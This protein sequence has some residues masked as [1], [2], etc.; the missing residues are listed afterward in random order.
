MCHWLT[1]QFKI[2][3]LK[4]DRGFA[5]VCERGNRVEKRSSGRFNAMVTN[6]NT[7]TSA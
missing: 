1:L 6:R 7:L 5:N 2:A 4:T 3:Q